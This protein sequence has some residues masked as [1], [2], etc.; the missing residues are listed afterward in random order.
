MIAG[1]AAMASAHYGPDTLQLLQ[2]VLDEAWD[3]FSPAQ[4]ADHSKLEL[5]ERILKRAAEGE[6]DPSRLRAAALGD[7]GSSPGT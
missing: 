6:R 4:Q 3:G 1:E 2:R 5:A 7:N